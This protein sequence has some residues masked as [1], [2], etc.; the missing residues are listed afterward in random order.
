MEAGGGGHRETSA[1]SLE[2]LAKDL[3]ISG[4]RFLHLQ[5]GSGEHHGIKPELITQAPAMGHYI[6]MSRTS[7][8]DPPA[9][10]TGACISVTSV[11]GELAPCDVVVRE[12][13]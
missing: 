12:Q 6:P 9:E 3:Y 13:G 11:P 2:A 1:G 8:S 5:T 7:V 10:G 4:P